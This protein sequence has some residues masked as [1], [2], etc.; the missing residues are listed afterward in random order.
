MVYH[1][2][3][4][5]RYDVA[6]FDRGQSYIGT[7]WADKV[8]DFG[9]NIV[10]GLQ[11]A[12]QDQEGWYDDVLRGA[13][14]VLSGAGAVMN[15]PGIK[16]AMQVL[17]A[18]SHY[19][20][21]LGGHLAK[22]IGIDPRI[23]GLAGNLVG[24][25]VTGGFVRKA[26]KIAGKLS[27]QAASFAARNI[28]AQTVSAYNK[29]DDLPQNIKDIQIARKNKGNTKFLNELAEKTDF[30][31]DYISKHGRT[32]T[33]Q[34]Q[35][36]T[37]PDTGDQFK[38]MWKDKRM[39]WRNWT[40][41]VKQKLTRLNN[42]KPDKQS[43]RPIMEKH[44][45]SKHVDAATDL[46][47]ETNTK[48]F[49]EVD[50]A[51][52][53]HNK[54]IKAKKKA[55][56]KTKAEINDKADL[57]SLEHIFDVNFYERLKELVPNFQARG[58]NE[59]GNI[60]ALNNVLNV[61]TGAMNKKIST[62]DALIKNIQSGKGFPDYNKSIGDFVEHD[63]GNKV[64]NFS[65]DQWDDFLQQVIQREDVNVQEILIDMIKTDDLVEDVRRMTIRSK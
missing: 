3:D 54:A 42:Q 36:I 27:D 57:L 14:S 48:V 2:V 11:A 24:D 45:G 37:M 10:S 26:P 4:K 55:A 22:S 61:K 31:D 58:A 41:E 51:I 16:Q 23:G 40:Q 63:V 6:A 64:K 39:S 29:F 43:I 50:N 17:D 9:R 15:A 12:S 59:M 56:G 46:Y 53:R 32:Y 28:P 60:S 7:E 44:V 30:M 38:Y 62:H 49:N 65:K 25:A 21:K 34:N 19:G 52:K 1:P 18:G 35:F 47:V 5:E 20:G 33:G 8:E 13:G